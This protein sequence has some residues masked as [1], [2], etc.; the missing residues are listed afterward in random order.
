MIHSLTRN[1]TVKAHTDIIV[2]SIEKDDYMNIFM[3]IK[4]GQE[5]DYIRFLREIKLLE[6]WPINE[7]PYNDARICLSSYFRKG[8]VI[9]SNSQTNEW[10]Y[11]IKQGT[12]RILK[13]FRVLKEDMIKYSKPKHCLTTKRSKFIFKP[14]FNHIKFHYFYFFI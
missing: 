7:L 9:C 4:K 12:C 13:S 2:L 8:V 6:G 1:A 14:C 3:S 10:I 11:I 5:P